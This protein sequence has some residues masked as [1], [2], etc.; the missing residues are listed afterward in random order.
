MVEYAFQLAE[1]QTG[2]LKG[3][4]RPWLFSQD[5]PPNFHLSCPVGPEARLGGVGDVHLVG[6]RQNE[7]ALTNGLYGFRGIEPE[8][9]AQLRDDCLGPV[10]AAGCQ[11]SGSG[12]NVANVR[13]FF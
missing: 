7:V 6:P 4:G 5:A 2:H 13:C 11:P 8:P 1:P 10:G 12:G 3:R 9:L